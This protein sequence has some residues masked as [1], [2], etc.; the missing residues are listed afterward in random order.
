VRVHH[1]AFRTQQ[2][3]KVV[4]FYCSVLGL[5]VVREQ[6]L[7]NGTIRSVWLAADR[8]IVMI[9]AAEIDEPRI[10]PRSNELVAFKVPKR[11]VARMRAR[12]LR[13]R[14]RIEAETQHSCYFRDPDGRRVAFTTFSWPLAP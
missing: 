13:H 11:D 2:L 12:L 1:L 3:R 7:S 4:R 5:A 8:T 6:R 14:I 9:E 10:P